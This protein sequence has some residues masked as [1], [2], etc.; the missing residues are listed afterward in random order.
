MADSKRSRDRTFASEKKNVVSFRSEAETDIDI[1]N[2]RN[3]D[4]QQKKIRRGGY[5]KDS[6]SV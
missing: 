1:S 6:W 2:G 4:T 5:E 3:R